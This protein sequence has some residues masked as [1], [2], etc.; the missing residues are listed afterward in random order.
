MAEKQTTTSNTSEIAGDFKV[1]FAKHKGL[2]KK[3]QLFLRAYSMRMLNISTAIKVV[4]IARSTVYDW[5]NKSD[6]FKK[7]KE[8][9]EENFFD[10]I[11]TAIFSKAIVEKDNTMLIFLAKTKMKSRGYIEAEEHNVTLNPFEDLMKRAS[12]VEEE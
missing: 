3:Q 9:I 5:I 1:F 8:E 4:G 7:A 11:E 2:S 6:T 12:R 10:G